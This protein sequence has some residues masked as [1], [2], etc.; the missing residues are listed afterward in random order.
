MLAMDCLIK[1]VEN[2]TIDEIANL[3]EN[4][5]GDG[6]VAAVVKGGLLFVL[7]CIVYSLNFYL[8][9]VQE[10]FFMIFSLTRK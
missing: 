6:D 7:K 4:V 5:S 3:L 10:I 9:N 2:Y 1:D 8:K